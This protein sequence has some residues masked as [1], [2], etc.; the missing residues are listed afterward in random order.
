MMKPN[1]GGESVRDDM[2]EGKK[3]SAMR[4]G[5]I[6]RESEEWVESGFIEASQRERIIASYVPGRRVLPRAA[7]LLGVLMIGLGLLNFVAANWYR[8]TPTW[9]VSLIVALYLATLGGAFWSDWAE[10]PLV[11]ESLLFFSGFV[12]LGGIFLISQTFHTEG[13]YV[14]ALALW[15]VGFLPTVLLFRSLSSLLTMHVVALF[16][17]GSVLFLSFGGG[18]GLAGVLSFSLEPV[19]V[20]LVLAA[21]TGWFYLLE[22]GL[23]RGART[24]SAAVSL[25]LVTGLT[26]VGVLLARMDLR[27]I[28]MPLF[29]YLALGMGIRFFGERA[30][31]AGVDSLGLAVTGISGILLTFPFAWGHSFWQ[32]A[33]SETMA[34]CVAVS[35][36]VGAYLLWLIVR[37]ERQG[38]FAAFL[39][40]AL[41]VRWYFDFVASFMSKSLFFFTGGLLLIL[42]PLIFGRLR[43]KKGESSE[44]GEG[45]R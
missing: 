6:R 21:L 37:R 27:E 36:F 13:H 2:R 33:A 42:P 31:I 25:C 24:L 30:E 16:Y 17:M 39:F 18:Y 28:T 22:G 41:L 34:Y 35:V 12:F 7:V 1:R 5:L 38:T 43:R 40:C 29:V 15:M 32:E 10:R 8:I 20:L 3:I 14:R 26:A 45:S 9:R 23:L 11:S 44:G 4:L 19:M